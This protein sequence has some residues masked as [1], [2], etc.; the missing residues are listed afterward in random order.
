MDSR[1]QYY[2]QLLEE[3]AQQCQRR[4]DGHAGH[5][6][7][8]NQQLLAKLAQLLEDFGRSQDYVAQATHIVTTLIRDYPDIVPLMPR[9]I[10]WFCGSECLHFL[11]DD[12]LDR[13][14]LIEERYYDGG[15]T[16]NYRDIRAQVFG[17]H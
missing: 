11:G 5:N 14:Q 8:S 3:L 6:E 12:E 1:K 10:L 15:D 13:Y 16:A 9:D 7:E 4:V 2:R 17:L